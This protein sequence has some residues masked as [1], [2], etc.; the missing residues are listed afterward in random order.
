MAGLES[1]NIPNRGPAEP[2]GSGAI[3]TWSI[4][5]LALSRPGA[6]L[7]CHIVTDPD[8][9]ITLKE[10]I[11]SWYDRYPD[12]AKLRK[13][14]LAWARKALRL[15]SDRRRREDELRA[16]RDLEPRI[17]H[18]RRLEAL[19]HEGGSFAV[20]LLL[21]EEVIK[22]AELQPKPLDWLV[23]RIRYYL[24][25]GLGRKVDWLLF[26]HRN[27]ADK[28]HLHGLLGVTHNELPMAIEALQRALGR[29]PW[30]GKSQ[31]HFQRDQSRSIPNSGWIGYCLDG[32]ASKDNGYSST[33]SLTRKAK[34]LHA[35]AR[36]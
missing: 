15:A 6:A 13:R 9:P 31:F 23:D 8:T 36:G 19:E 11:D 32:Q 27:K 4:N 7:R 29:C 30:R 24:N 1:R 22:E 5:D 2:S 20:T 16:W 26:D 28:L 18:L 10:H 25:A 3:A 21:S 33:Q 17:Q 34:Q 35:K 14:S 12:R